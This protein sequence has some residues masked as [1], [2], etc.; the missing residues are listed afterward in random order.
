MKHAKIF[1]ILIFSIVA[2]YAAIGF[3]F[4]PLTNFEGDQ[5]RT[6]LLPES[7]FGWTMPQPA[8]E[9]ALIQQATWTNADVLVVGD[10]FSISR[11]WQTELVNHGLRV[12]TEHWANI[13]GICE[14]FI[15]WL[16]SRGFQG[17]YIVLEAVE[18]NITSGLA[19]SVRCKKMDYH[20][21]FDADLPRSAPPTTIDRSK[22]D[23]SGK[24]SIGFQTQINLSKYEQLSSHPDFKRWDTGRGSIVVR[25]DRGCERFSH[26]HCADALFLADDSPQDLSTDV[27]DNMQI[28]NKRLTGFN[29]LWVVV[30]NKTTAYL[31]PEKQFW[32][33]AA[34]RVNTVNLL[35]SVRQAI[36]ENTVD[37][38]PANN[39]HFSTTTYLL[40]GRA[41]YQ[42]LA[43]KS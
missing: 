8:I 31:Y 4:L 5:T 30:P 9:P 36:E 18:R 41:I 14:D 29:P 12:R 24:I 17:K 27:V 39:T 35:K 32:N 6:G 43:G 10:S 42:A 33:K 19:D 28:L 21:S 22:A 16:R 25:V 13:R 3:Y 1:S 37:V 23:Y 11:V 38:Y 2:L 20:P 26:P 15:P 7:L 34:E 40:M